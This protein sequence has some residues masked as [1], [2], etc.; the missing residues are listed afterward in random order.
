M[1]FLRQLQDL[2][3]GHGKER[4]VHYLELLPIPE[5]VK[6][7][8]LSSTAKVPIYIASSDKDMLKVDFKN[9]PASLIRETLF[10]LYGT[11]VFRTRLVTGRGNNPGTY[12]IRYDVLKSIYAFVNNHVDT[13]K[14]L[15]MHQVVQTINKRAEDWRKKLSTKPLKK[16]RSK[17]LKLSEADSPPSLH[18]KVIDVISAPPHQDASS[19]RQD[20]RTPPQ[21]PIHEEAPGTP[22]QSAPHQAP[23]SRPLHGAPGTPQ[24]SAPHQATPSG[25]LHGAPGTPQQSAPHQAP[26]S[27]PLHG[28]PGT[29]Q[30]S[31]PHHAPPSGPLHGAPG[32][33]QQSATHHAPPSGPLHGAPGTP[34]GAPF[35]QAPCFQPEPSAWQSNP[36]QYFYPPN[37]Q[38]PAAPSASYVPT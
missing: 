2:L 33:P 27:G 9:K 21:A 12:G 30:Q 3:E 18:E 29:P 32:T 28:A 1:S 34:Y 25:P 16:S 17:K 23:P 20:A 6:K 7:T 19:P 22:Q 35:S 5:N 15:K 11:E 13:S 10:S 14:R 24:Q 4:E 26:P 8:E 36:Y 31:A 37:Y 38:W